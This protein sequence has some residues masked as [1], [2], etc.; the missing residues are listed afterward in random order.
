MSMEMS[1]L[2]RVLELNGEEFAFVRVPLVE[3][4]Q[5]ANAQFGSIRRR[6]SWKILF[7]A[8]NRQQ[9]TQQ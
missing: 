7:I 3:L 4:R 1:F 5:T 9:L 8:V 2:T 6:R